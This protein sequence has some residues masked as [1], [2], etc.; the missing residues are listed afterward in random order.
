MQL[1]R[2]GGDVQIL[3][4]RTQVD[5]LVH[6]GQFQCA[7]LQGCQLATISH[8]L[9]HIVGRDLDIIRDMRQPGDDIS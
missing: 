5:P 4:G 9:A 2:R 6:Y 8:I 7:L 3:P 1:T